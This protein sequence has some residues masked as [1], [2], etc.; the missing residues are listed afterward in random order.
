MREYKKDN[1]S[2]YNTYLDANNL[3]RWVL[4][5]KLPAD[6]LEWKKSTSKFNVNLIKNYDSDIGYI[7]EVDIKYPKRLHNITMIYRFYQK[8]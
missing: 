4:S 3:Y 2:S 1:E 8:E 5:Q 6:S 7:L